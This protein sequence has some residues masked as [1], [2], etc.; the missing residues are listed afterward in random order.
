MHYLDYEFWYLLRFALV[1]S[2]W[3]SEYLK[4]LLFQYML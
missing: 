1:I 4:C 3:V 2:I